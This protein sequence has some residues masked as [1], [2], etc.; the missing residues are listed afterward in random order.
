MDFMKLYKIDVRPKQEGVI[1]VLLL[2]SFLFV[3][4]I[5]LIIRLIVE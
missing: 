4:F 3:C 5:G 1:E 2:K